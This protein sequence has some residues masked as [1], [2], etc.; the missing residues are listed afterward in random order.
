MLKVVKMFEYSVTPHFFR[1]A[2]NACTFKF[3]SMI[4]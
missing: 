4:Q 3:L 2:V 1:A